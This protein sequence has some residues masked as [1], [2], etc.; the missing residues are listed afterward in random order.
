MIDIGKKFVCPRGRNICTL[1][2]A[3]IGPMSKILVLIGVF[4]PRD[5]GQGEISPMSLRERE[6]ENLFDR[7]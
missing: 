1:L 3:V 6:R 4:G 7:G 5:E 2:F